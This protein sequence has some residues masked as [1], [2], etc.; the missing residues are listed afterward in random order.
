MNFRAARLDDRGLVLQIFEEGQGPVALHD[1][2]IAFKHVKTWL[3][4]SDKM[5]E[6][7]NLA[8]ITTPEKP[9]FDSKTHI[10]RLVPAFIGGPPA[11][12]WELVERPNGEALAEFT[13]QVKDQA[14]LLWGRSS[15][16]KGRTAWLDH[17]DALKAHGV[18][19][20][21]AFNQGQTVEVVTGTV[22]GA[23]GWPT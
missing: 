21:Q 14:W 8:A 6:V 9:P 19:L 3:R 2:T 23:G 18:S 10:V 1:R 22:N 5:A 11:D 16:S 4:Q 17:R 15:W 13:E 12:T 7:Y 20:V